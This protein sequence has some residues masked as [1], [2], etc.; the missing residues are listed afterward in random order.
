MTG[1]SWSLREAQLMTVSS[2]EGHDGVCRAGV[3]PGDVARQ[4]GAA[5]PGYASGG[6]SDHWLP[7]FHPAR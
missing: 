6:K 7:A 3:A 4:R 5:E 2:G 1:R